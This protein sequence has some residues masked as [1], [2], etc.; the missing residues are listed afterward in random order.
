VHKRDSLKES[1]ENK[2]TTISGIYVMIPRIEKYERLKRV[3]NSAS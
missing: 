3:G 2:D 1:I